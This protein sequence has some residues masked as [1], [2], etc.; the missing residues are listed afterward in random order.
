MGQESRIIVKLNRQ[1]N[2]LILSTTLLRAKA[3]QAR[4]KE[5][6]KVGE[7]ACNV[8]RSKPIP[9]EHGCYMSGVLPNTACADAKGSRFV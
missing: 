4:S 1:K 7:N 5:E 3:K 2:A 9:L 8:K 6:D